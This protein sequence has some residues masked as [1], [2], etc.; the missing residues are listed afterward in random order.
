MRRISIDHGTIWVCHCCTMQ[1]ANGECCGESEHG[2]DGI[3]PWS[4]IDLAR[5]A[6]WQGMP[7][8]EH[9]DTCDPSRYDCYCEVREFDR[10]RCQGCGSWL[11]GYRH[12]FTLTRERQRFVKPQLPA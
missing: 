7:R 9:D 4:S 12:A 11:G 8:D 1:H 5:F 10:G 6:A 2:G 3:A